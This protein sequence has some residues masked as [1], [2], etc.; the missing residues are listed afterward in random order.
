MLTLYFRSQRISFIQSIKMKSSRSLNSVLVD[1]WQSNSIKKVF[2]VLFSSLI[3][4]D[5]GCKVQFWSTC[6]LGK[7][8]SD[9]TCQD[10][11]SLIKH[12]PSSIPHSVKCARFFKAFRMQ[13]GT[14]MFT[15]WLFFFKNNH[16]VLF[17]WKWKFHSP[18]W[19]IYDFHLSEGLDTYICKWAS[20]NFKPCQWFQH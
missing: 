10:M 3:I 1:C 11:F 4:D 2:T 6:H 13:K 17:S 14:G 18:N 8:H 7:W 20:A 5:Q 15:L 19:V 16:S 9:C 12:L